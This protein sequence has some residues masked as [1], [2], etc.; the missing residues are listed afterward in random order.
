M[1][2]FDARPLLALLAL[3][4]PVGADGEPA[5]GEREGP[6]LVLTAR[7]IL[8]CT[9]EG[10]RVIDNGHL[11]LRDGKILG[12]GPGPGEYEGEVLREDCGEAWLMPGVVEMHSH[13]G[14]TF[15]IND[16]VF[17]TNP[18]LR[19]NTSVVPDNSMMQLAR[20]GGV[21]TI[22]YIPG[23]GT[24]M[25]G[26]G[27][28]IK[29][30]LDRF[31]DI[32]VRNPGCLKMAQAGNPERWCFGVGRSFMNWNTRNTYKRGLAYARSWKDYEEGRGEKP[33]VDLQLELFRQV[34]GGKLPILSHTQI[35]QVVLATITM[36][37]QELG[38][39]VFIG[40]GSFDAWR[41]G[42][43]AQEAGVGAVL[44]PRNADVPSTS[45]AR[46]SGSN[47]EKIVGIAAGYQQ[48]GHQMIAFNTDAPVVPQEELPLQAG[49]GVRL[50]FEN[51][52]MAAIRGLTIIP[53]M[54]G[55]VDGEIGSLEA[56]KDADVLILSGDVADP[57][58]WIQRVYV[59][60]Q[61]VYDTEREPRRW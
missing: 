3:A 10:P 26:Q 16:M 53:A 9:L 17:L 30:G 12:L 33:E 48:N 42:G 5:A 44:G 28:I 49:L 36:V 37:R 55:G 41:L 6:T 27:I 8:P 38:L 2:G 59:E 4:A 46:F 1:L 54:I 24:N 35:Y 21:T 13:I 50:G 34:S 61:V 56:G 29:T 22:L 47:P 45:M 14:G 23:S 7:K 20:A 31:D 11:A 40:H 15:D 52:D 19:A 58:T 32:V 39:N 51:R 18:E 43:L 60:G 57:R 25:G